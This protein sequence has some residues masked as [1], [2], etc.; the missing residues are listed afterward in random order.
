MVSFSLFYTRVLVEITFNNSE[1][2]LYNGYDDIILEYIGCD[3]G[4]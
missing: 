4:V 1:F 3:T 2:D